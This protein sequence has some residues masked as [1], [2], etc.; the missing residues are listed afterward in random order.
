MENDSEIYKY[1]TK[2]KYSRINQKRVI[3]EKQVKQSKQISISYTVKVDYYEYYDEYYEED[4][5]I[6]YLII[7]KAYLDDIDK[8]KKRKMIFFLVGKS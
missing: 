3:K 5:G 8:W 7:P 2:E 4:R 1:R 6:Y